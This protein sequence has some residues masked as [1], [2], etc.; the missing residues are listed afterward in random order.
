MK[1]GLVLA[2]IVVAVLAGG[3]LAQPGGRHGMPDRVM[4]RQMQRQMPP[5]ERRMTFEDRQR[6]REQVQNGQ[7]TRDQARQEW[8]EE[9]A[10]REL[11]P[12]WQQQREQMRRD[13]IE[14]NRNLQRR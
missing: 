2:G 7:M 12:N 10:R 13:V 1:L 6:L 5:P 3:A 11:D 4:Q 8:R 9:R 14:A